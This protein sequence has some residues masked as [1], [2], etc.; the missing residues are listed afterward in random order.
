MLAYYLNNKE[1]W[2]DEGT[3]VVIVNRN[4]AC[5]FDKLVDRAAL[6]V[7]IPLNQRNRAILGNPERFERYITP[8]DM[9]FTGFEIRYDGALLISGTLVIEGYSNG[10]YSGYV[11]SNL[12]A[13][14][15]AQQE[16]YINE[17][18]WPSAQNFSDQA[19]Y[20][21]ATDDYGIKE[22]YNLNFWEGKGRETDVQVDYY[23][24]EGYAQ[25]KEQIS[26]VIGYQFYTNY[27]SVVNRFD[28]SNLKPGCVISPFLY[29]R[30]VIKQS[31]KINGFYISRNDMVPTDG[32]YASSFIRNLMV[33]NN[34][35]ILDMAINTTPVQQPWW[36]YEYYQMI[37]KEYNSVPHDGFTWQLGLFNYNDLLPR[38]SYKEVLTGI[39]NLLNYILLFKT[40]NEVDIIDR[41]NILNTIA[42][43]LDNYFRGEWSIGEQKNLRLKFVSEIDKDDA[44]FSDEY[45]DLSDRWQDFKDPVATVADLDNIV[46]PD[47][48]ELRYV[49][50]VD[51]V[52][53]YG[54]Y[55][56]AAE[57]ADRI[58]DQIDV[59][60]WH[61]VS[62]GPQ[63]FIYGSGEEEEEIKTSISTTQRTYQGGHLVKQKGNISKMRSL[64]NNFT[65]RLLPG[66]A[67]QHQHS[68]YW[69]G[70]DGLFNR[71]WKQWADFWK[72]RLEV[73]AEFQLSL[74]MIIHIQNNITNKFSTIKGEFIIEEMETEIGMHDIGLTKIKGYKV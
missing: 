73:S 6:G 38:K 24:T 55:V 65:F 1:L 57:D 59:L 11:Q 43:D 16:K 35:N 32:G 13:M 21:D 47:F 7:D 31:L 3:S 20:D 9:K 26:S 46:S 64:W 74:N 34:F 40:N 70:D 30:Y 63:P 41:N 18:A 67:V 2:I 36:S 49:E 19:G 42:I 37:L 4:P 48:G 5:F 14:G 29:L 17:M 25:Q 50:D 61:L 8:G 60:G 69:D 51:E 22:V 23:D 53:E 28:I 72:S 52:H 54:L 33:Y 66:P 15:E 45:E 27:T 68:L 71:R 12:G 10:V 44:K 58:E 62:S 56:L 39:Q